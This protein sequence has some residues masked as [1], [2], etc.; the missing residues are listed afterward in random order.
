[1]KNKKGFTLVE[2]IGV[3]IVLGIVLG[4]ASVAYISISNHIKTTYY[5]GI[6]TVLLE[7]GGEYYTHNSEE[8]PQIFGNNVQV[9][10]ETL[11]NGKYV[12]E[13]KDRDGNSCEGYVGAYKN[14]YER[15]NYYVCLVCSEYETDNA[16]CYGDVNYS[17]QM[18]ATVRNTMTRYQE[19]S[20]VKDY[21]T[22]TFRTFNDIKEIKVENATGNVVKSCNVEVKN[23]LASCKIQVDETGEYTA[24]GV[25]E[26][27]SK[28]DEKEITIKIDNQ[29]PSFDI[30]ENGVM[31]TGKQE[32]DATNGNI[33]LIIDIRNIKDLESGIKS[34][35][36]SFEKEGKSSYQTVTPTK[37]EFRIEKTLE[38]GKYTLIVEIEDNAGN[39]ETKRIEYEVYK[40]LSIPTSDL[41]CN[42]LTYNGYEQVLTKSPGTG[43]TFINNRGTNV[44][45][46]TV[47]ARLNEDYR[48]SDG[49]NTD[50]TLTCTIKRL[51]TATI[52]S[53]R[54]LTYNGTSQLLAS[55]GDNVTYRN[56]Y[57]TNAGSYTV[58]I[59]TTNNYAFS[60][61]S[62][63]K[64]LTCSISKKNLT[65]IPN[66]N[67]SKT[68]GSSDPTLTYTYSGQISG[69]TP[70]FT[71]SLSRASGENVGTYLINRGTL[72]L[73]NNGAF[74]ANN[75]NLV[76]SG[77]VNFRINQKGVS[78]LTI[79]LQT[80]NYTYDGT[81]KTPDVTVRD[82]TTTLTNGTHYT[83]SYNNN[84]NAGTATVTITGRGNYSGTT[85]KTF[86]IGKRSVTIKANNQ[87]LDG[88]TTIDK[89]LS[90]ITTSNLV[91]GHSVTSI[92]L[93]QSTTATTTSGTITP[94]SA[95]IKS[96]TTDVTSNYNITYQTGILVINE[97][98]ICA[99]F[100]LNGS[101]RVNGQSNDL[102]VCC[103]PANGASSCTISTPTI[104]PSTGF[105]VLG[106]SD[107]GDNLTSANYSQ[108]QTITIYKNDNNNEDDIQ[109]FYAVT[110][111]NSRNSYEIT[112]NLNGATSYTTGGRTYT[113]TQTFTCSADYAYNGDEL[114]N[115]CSITLPTI[116]R[117][118]GTV[119]GWDENSDNQGS[120]A[121]KQNSIYVL[122]DD[123]EL[124]AIT[125]KQITLT[126]NN[127][128]TSCD[129][130]ISDNLTSKSE[131]KTVYNG[132]GI[133]F[134]IPSYENGKVCRSQGTNE[135]FHGYKILGLGTS[136]TG[137][138][139]EYCFGDQIYL[140]SDKTLYAMWQDVYATALG[141]RSE[142][143]RLRSGAGTSYSQ[144][145]SIRKG[146][147]I[148]VKSSQYTWNDDDEHTW[149]PVIFGSQTGWAAANTRNNSSLVNF[150]LTSTPESNSCN[151]T[152]SCTS[153]NKLLSITPSDVV[154]NITPDTTKQKMEETLTINN[155]C[156]PITTATS[157]DTS[158]VTATTSGVVKAV[159]G[160]VSENQEKTTTVTYTTRYGCSE[161][162]NVK[163]KNTNATA[164]EITISISGNSSTCSGSYLKGA[165]ATVRCESDLPITEYSAK[166]GSSS[167]PATTT[168]NT[169]TSTILLSS[170]GSKT[171][172]VTCANSEGTT[173]NSR[174]VSIKVRSA[175]SACGCSSY[176]TSSSAG[177]T[178]SRCSSWSYAWDGSYSGTSKKSTYCSTSGGN[179]YK[180]SYSNW[181]QS[182]GRYTADT[183]TYRCS[184]FACRSYKTCCHN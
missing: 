28:T 29:K 11:V 133:V 82:G 140:E 174:T 18:T 121:Y 37:E 61:G 25:S 57:G 115:S 167:Y 49:T 122:Y 127:N 143:L 79:T 44:G 89:S 105:A 157:S 154:L 169:K 123:I 34:I 19:G 141:Q 93:T 168:G 70:R 182:S 83:V 24:Y 180:T 21:V 9:S 181:S 120:P 165:T 117:S 96:G 77:N 101:S 178:C 56:A 1:M 75:Y 118:G 48:W 128:I 46:Y 62:I 7:A 107:D 138:T 124:Y 5:R 139:V 144:I 74:L 35:R 45:S 72:A 3:V 64:N 172:N 164:P 184:K 68:Y 51:Q 50:K 94:S 142:N 36:Y 88:T 126:Y 66:N 8:A 98:K 16:A 137:N 153:N 20:Y 104:T 176:Y 113:Q 175:S 156:G 17:L 103:Q 129:K 65:V 114:P 131:T 81:A 155:Q 69:E 91:T 90:Q 177:R 10:I 14:S 162:V 146:D 159:S 116:A 158:L 41:Y 125:S 87:T 171:I 30:Y 67:Q 4:L 33:N 150:T 99:T 52:G 2:I 110:R 173:T 85:T 27:G 31:I 53:C 40:R 134:N 22:L 132:E 54:S 39:K 60:D 80:N 149:Y 161:S 32:K 12:E 84:I 76:L 23:G 15:T 106:W 13:V 112:Y 147:P 55:G 109:R 111:S 160:S 38:T 58:T 63:T 71:G 95:I 119:Y 73:T 148:Y 92:T 152:Y 130:L 170:T 179:F 42:N 166:I 86:T 108:N 102:E 183:K 43:F 6:E 163:V 151:Y 97:S 59:N 136:S 135:R 100:M 78:N 145:G 26:N 47:T